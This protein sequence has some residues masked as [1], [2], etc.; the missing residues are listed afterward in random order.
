VA[1]DRCTCL[2]FHFGIINII[3]K[4]DGALEPTVSTGSVADQIFCQ[5]CLASQVLGTKLPIS[6]IPL[7]P[8][9]AAYLPRRKLTPA[10]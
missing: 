7:V 6:D 2:T 5:N 10:T 8:R 3:Q 1:E 9:D 4:T